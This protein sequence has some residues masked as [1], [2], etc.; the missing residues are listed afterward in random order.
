M[1]CVVFAMGVL[2]GGTFAIWK[3]SDWTKIF[4]VQDESSVLFVCLF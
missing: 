1:Y 3:A 2:G 4:A